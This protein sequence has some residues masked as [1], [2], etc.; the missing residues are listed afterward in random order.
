MDAGATLT[1]AFDFLES[2]GYKVR[3]LRGELNVRAIGEFFQYSNFIAYCP[4]LLGDI[5][6]WPPCRPA[7]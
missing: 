6:D 1:R 7:L 4:S 3:L 2:N 5:L